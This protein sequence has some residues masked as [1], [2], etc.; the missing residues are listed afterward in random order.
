MGTFI[1]SFI[2]DLQTQT[3]PYEDIGLRV[4]DCPVHPITL[5][6]CVSEKITLDEI[7]NVNN[8]QLKEA[9]FKMYKY[10]QGV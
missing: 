3:G 6:H 10:N 5:L 7:N 2:N 4:E 1:G 8:A 9:L